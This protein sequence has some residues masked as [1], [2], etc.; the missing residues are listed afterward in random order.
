MPRDRV[1]RSR[2][3]RATAARVGTR[4]PVRRAA[5][6]TT[7]RTNSTAT[8]AR[9]APRRL[10]AMWSGSRTGTPAAFVT[11]TAASIETTAT[12]GPASAIRCGCHERSRRRR[13]MRCRR[14][15]VSGNRAAVVGRRSIG[16]GAPR[17]AAGIGGKGGPP[18]SADAVKHLLSRAAAVP[19]PDTRTQN[20]AGPLER[21]PAPFPLSF[22]PGRIRAA[23]SE[24]DLLLAERDGQSHAAAVGLGRHAV[25]GRRLDRGA[26]DVDLPGARR[27]DEGRADQRSVAADGRAVVDADVV[28][29]LDV[30]AAADGPAILAVE[31]RTERVAPGVERVRR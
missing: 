6:T 10:P 31:L 13:G 23:E 12:S 25:A 11:I 19:P 16:T 22:P 2:R 26:A 3:T 4:R 21:G 20:D 27:V 1:Q 9:S 29:D 30:R 17:I 14:A 18:E 8:S 24:S 15:S 7:S 5:R 28:G